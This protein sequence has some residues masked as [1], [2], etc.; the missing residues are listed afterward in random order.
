MKDIWSIVFHLGYTSAN[1]F[2]KRELYPGADLPLQT[3]L[4]ECPKATYGWGSRTTPPPTSQVGVIDP[5][6]R[7]SCTALYEPPCSGARKQATKVRTQLDWHM[8]AKFRRCKPQRTFFKK[9][10]FLAFFQFSF[11]RPRSYSISVGPGGTCSRLCDAGWL[12][13]FQGWSP[14]A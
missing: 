10:P 8:S 1:L 6:T 14:L 7:P 13:H 4:Y 11:V 5:P 3:C 2:V 12:D 9:M